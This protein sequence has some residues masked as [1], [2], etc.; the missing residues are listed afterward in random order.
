MV[1]ILRYG[2]LLFCFGSGYIFL[3]FYSNFWFTNKNLNLE[4]RFFKDFK[5][6]EKT[7]QFLLVVC[8]FSAWVGFGSELAKS[9]DPNYVNTDLQRCFFV[10]LADAVSQLIV[11]VTAYSLQAVEEYPGNKQANR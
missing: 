3:Q 2:T 11:Q 6:F 10:S 1:W 4:F 9:W 5:I 8:K 7:N